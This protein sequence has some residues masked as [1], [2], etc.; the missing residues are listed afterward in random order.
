MT[1]SRIK[2]R[3]KLRTVWESYCGWRTKNKLDN[4]CSPHTIKT[5]D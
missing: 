5:A 4:D 3:S 1:I 2:R